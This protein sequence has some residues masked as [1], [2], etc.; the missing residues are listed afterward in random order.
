MACTNSAPPRLLRSTPA[1]RRGVFRPDAASSRRSRRREPSSRRFGGRGSTPS[2]TTSSTVV[3]TRPEVD[4]APHR[5]SAERARSRRCCS[6]AG[7]RRSSAGG[8]GR[9]RVYARRC[10]RSRS[11]TAGCAASTPRTRPAELVA[12]LRAALGRGE[13]DVVSL[14]GAPRRFRLPHGGDRGSLRAARTA[15]VTEDA[16]DAAAARVV[17]GVHQVA[18][19]EDEARTSASTEPAPARPRRRALARA[20][21][22]IRPSW[23]RCSAPRSRRSPR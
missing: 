4:P 10:A 19:E 7:S 22:T 16:Q 18:L 2:R 12:T 13:A 6:S 3:R 20:S 14:P 15:S 11:C 17:R 21:S 5:A 9:L 23:T 8:L 1:I